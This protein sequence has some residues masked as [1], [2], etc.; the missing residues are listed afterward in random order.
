MKSKPRA[1]ASA[2]SSNE[3]VRRVRQQAQAARQI[4]MLLQSLTWFYKM[5]QVAL[6]VIATLL[7]RGLY[8]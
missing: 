6:K 4:M 2:R 5:D 8:G 1:A 3:L 7:V